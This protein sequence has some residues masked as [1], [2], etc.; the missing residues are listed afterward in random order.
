M[1][2]FAAEDAHDPTIVDN[3]GQAA[4]NGW[5]LNQRNKWADSF[6]VG[7]RLPQDAAKRLARRWA[8]AT[9]LCQYAYSFLHMFT[10]A[11]WV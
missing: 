11:R 5:T 2:L 8:S 9:M 1:D 7:H 6:K 4:N 3:V 10:S